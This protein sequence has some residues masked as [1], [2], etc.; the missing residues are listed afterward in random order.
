M[1]CAAGQAGK[2]LIGTLLV[3]TTLRCASS[4][5][6][7]TPQ[8]RDSEPASR[9]GEDSAPPQDFGD[10]A[11]AF[12]RKGEMKVEEGV[13]TTS[14]P[15]SDLSVEIEGEPVPT[16]LGFASWVAF[17][18]GPRGAVA[19]SDMVLLSDEVDPVLTTLQANGIEVTALHRHFR[20]EQPQL[21]YLHS[22]ASGDAERIARGYRAALERTATP[23]R[24]EAGAEQPAAALDTG[25][26]EAIVG[27]KGEARGGVYKITIGRDDL[28][29]N[30]GGVRVTKSLGL[31]SWAAF[32]GTDGR[33]HV[34]G[35]LAMLEDEVNP[36]VRALRANGIAIVSV[37]NHMI[38][39]EPRIFF[40]HYWGTGEAARLARAF[41]AALDELGPP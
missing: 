30:V 17:K 28:T 29:V 38:G 33:A 32:V 12:G 2:I 22:H 18:S 3:A 24:E 9:R 36:V 1:S 11:E 21:M 7:G 35:D 8:E 41:R 34:A 13:Y 4:Q 16:A 39:E 10:I 5:T 6:I 14:F 31:N 25:A 15:R 23:M 40:L 37:H 19:M 27:E 26:I 20:G